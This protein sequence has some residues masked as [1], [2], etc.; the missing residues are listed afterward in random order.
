MVFLLGLVD[1]GVVYSR[2][3]LI[4]TSMGNWTS[5]PPSNRC[6]CF[7]FGLMQR[8]PDSRW[9]AKEKGSICK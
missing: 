1:F 6:V 8:L 3:L 7:F 2:M 5:L 9:K 4:P